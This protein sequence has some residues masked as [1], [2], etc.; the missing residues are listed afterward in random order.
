MINLTIHEQAALS[1]ARVYSNP[2]EIADVCQPLL[3]QIMLWQF[4]ESVVRGQIKEV[5]YPFINRSVQQACNT[6]AQADL[7]NARL[8]GQGVV[9]RYIQVKRQLGNALLP[10]YSQRDAKK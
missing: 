8:M 5:D 7:N 2:A 4:G 1:A 10:Q 6:I 3:R 9:Q